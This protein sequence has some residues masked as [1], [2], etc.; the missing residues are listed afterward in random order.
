MAFD[1]ERLFFADVD[2]DD[3]DD[4]GRGGDVGKG[5]GRIG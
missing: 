1:V 5:G 4:V 2:A 3:D